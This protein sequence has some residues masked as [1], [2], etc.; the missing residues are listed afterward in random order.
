MQF[1]KSHILFQSN[2]IPLQ[3]RVGMRFYECKAPVTFFPLAPASFFPLPP[4]VSWVTRS[5]V[6]FTQPE[7]PPP[8]DA[9]SDC[10]PNLFLLG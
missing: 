7:A 2:S 5:P 6:I 10:F 1:T 4:Y 9:T 8:V 3:N